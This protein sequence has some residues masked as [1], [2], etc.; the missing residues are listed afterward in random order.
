MPERFDTT[1]EFVALSVL[2]KELAEV[3]PRAKARALILGM[4]FTFSGRDGWTNIAS[5]RPSEPD[6]AKAAAAWWDRV[7]PVFRRAVRDRTAR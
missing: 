7:E 1:P 3:L 5:L 6:A 2:V 4:G